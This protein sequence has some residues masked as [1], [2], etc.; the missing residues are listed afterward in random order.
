MSARFRV[1]F[2]GTPDFAVPSFSALHQAHDVICV[3]TQPPRP[4]GRGQQERLSPVARAARE[5][6]LMVR[7]PINFKTP[8]TVAD[9]SVLGA[10][11][12]NCGGLW[13]DFA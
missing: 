12:A 9:F 5:L 10:D 2:M 8:E 13:V 11:L 6:G 7:H 1:I 3:Y 4:A